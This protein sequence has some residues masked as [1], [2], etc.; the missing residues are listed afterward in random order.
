MR[1]ELGLGVVVE[2]LHGL[3]VRRR[4]G[5][6][7]FFDEGVGGRGFLFV[8][9]VAGADFGRGRGEGAAYQFTHALK[10]HHVAQGGVEVALSIGP[11]AKGT[12][13]EK[14]LIFRRIELT[15]G[16]ETT[17][18]LHE[19]LK[20]GP[21]HFNAEFFRF[22]AQGCHI[23]AE[24][25]IQILTPGGTIALGD[26]AHGV[27]VKGE[28]IGIL[29]KLVSAIQQAEHEAALAVELH[30]VIPVI[31]HAIKGRERLG[32]R[33][34]M[35][36]AG[37]AKENESHAHQNG[38]EEHEN[39]VMLA[40]SLEHGGVRVGTYRE[41]SP[42]GRVQPGGKGAECRSGGGQRQV[43]FGPRDGGGS[44]SGPFPDTESVCKPLPRQSCGFPLPGRGGFHGHSRPECLLQQ[45]RPEGPLRSPFGREQFG[46]TH[47]C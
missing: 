22:V 3:I 9:G 25:Q 27:R 16:L 35:L 42:A 5:L 14:S 38:D 24:I 46:M 13:G 45:F 4:S 17:H 28:G 32:V 1:F 8:A 33:A 39:V 26:A 18:R 11:V 2:F 37:V 6:L 15:V 23:H 30:K 47:L 12:A 36:H 43:L 44:R 41:K 31:I 21:V 40:E 19:F 10:Q 20:V 29:R 7:G 34:A